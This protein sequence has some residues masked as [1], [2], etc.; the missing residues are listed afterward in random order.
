M[1]PPT[2]IT[3]GFYAKLLNKLKTFYSTG[4]AHSANKSTWNI[5]QNITYLNLILTIHPSHCLIFF[6]KAETAVADDVSFQ[7]FPQDKYNGEA[8]ECTNCVK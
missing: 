5:I 7:C 4:I 3:V 6:K 1:D 8:M 2:Y